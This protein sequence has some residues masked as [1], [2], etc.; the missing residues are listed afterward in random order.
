VSAHFSTAARRSTTM[1]RWRYGG[2]VVMGLA[3]LAVVFS[4]RFRSGTSPSSL[5][6]QA[7]E[8]A[9]GG[10]G[11]ISP[12]QLQALAVLAPW[13]ASK[14][15]RA[16]LLREIKQEASKVGVKLDRQASAATEAAV[17]VIGRRAAV[18][19]QTDQL[20]GGHVFDLAAES[21]AKLLKTIKQ[22]QHMLSEMDLEAGEDIDEPS[23]AAK[24]HEKYHNVFD[25][26]PDEDD[27]HS[28]WDPDVFKSQPGE[29]PRDASARSWH[30]FPPSSK[31]A[32]LD[33]SGKAKGWRGEESALSALQ[34][35]AEARLKKDK[36]AR[37]DESS[38]GRKGNE[39]L[40]VDDS[41]EIVPAD[42]IAAVS[43]SSAV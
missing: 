3:G 41:G 19:E 8:A 15:Q 43:I 12:G 7:F 32:K 40:D 13:A 5:T 4:M 36:L 26:T 21:K 38:V 33:A 22:Q 2:V 1:E 27:A 25:K 9:D 24:R 16:A 17:D 34:T 31:L 29:D 28:N 37:E 39:K 35:K 6:L 30:L 23:H 42:S 14:A 20:A 11:R 10:S 18:V